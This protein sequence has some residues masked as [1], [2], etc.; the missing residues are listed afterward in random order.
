M[1]KA[2]KP[3]TRKV[4]KTKPKTGTT[5][6]T[7][8][9]AKAGQKIKSSEESKPKKVTRTKAVLPKGAKPKARAGT[10]PE[11][12][13][14][15]VTKPGV[16]IKAEKKPA[17]KA[18]PAV[19]KKIATK[20][21][22]PKV[23]PALKSKAKTTVAKK[24]L[25]VAAPKKATPKPVLKSPLKKVASPAKKRV[26]TQKKKTMP[27]KIAVP[28]AAAKK[29][30]VAEVPKKAPAQAQKKTT[31]QPA[32]PSKKS[33]EI[34]VKA[35]M[36]AT[37]KSIIATAKAVKLPVKKTALVQATSRIIKTE[38]SAKIPGDG[39]P[40][41]RPVAKKSGVRKPEEKPVKK[42]GKTLARP[43]PV[44]TEKPAVRKESRPVAKTTREIK[45]SKVSKEPARKKQTQATAPTG[46]PLKKNGTVSQAA[47][48]VAA[49]PEDELLS[50]AEIEAREGR[51]IKPRLKIFLPRE[52]IREQTLEEKGNKPGTGRE[53]LPAEYGDS[54]F[55]MIVIDPILIFLDWEIMPEDLPAEG[56]SLCVRIYDVTG[57][58]FDGTNAH[59]FIDIDLE[60]LAGSGY[61]EIGM[62]GREIV[63]EIGV[64]D[65]HGVFIVLLRSARASVP[66]LLQYDE[67]GIVRKMQEAGL[68]VGY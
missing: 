25:K 65:T 17:A 54:E 4:T 64:L 49:E 52:E 11:T 39:K 55:F 41:P 20:A 38:P 67:L 1:K 9:K 19:K 10:K 47:P 58:T 59:S 45:V 12:K 13:A 46:V 5:A 28:A 15:P 50:V 62:Q 61:C 42:I 40:G 29:K 31:P 2:T 6:K 36:K 63:A 7:A 8:G 68:P 60:G 3:A 35:P 14:A 22:P 53:S 57:I 18:K 56:L 24:P 48:V 37:G 30:A 27:V 21:T 66:P 26:D 51:A 43:I 32:A 34:P 44:T 33:K 23:K 16:R